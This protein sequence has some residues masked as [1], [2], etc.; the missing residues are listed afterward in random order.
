MSLF[1]DGPP[2]NIED[3]T[4]QDSGLLDVCRVQQI[5]ASVKL[6]LAHRELSAQ[7]ESL[8]EQ[9]RSVYSGTL[10]NSQL[11]LGN[12]AITPALR[13]WHT[14]QAL[15]LIYRDAY[16]NQLNDRFQAKWAEYRRLADNERNNL[17]DIGVGIVWDP[18]LQPNG[19]SLSPTPASEV[20][21]TFYFSIAVLNSAGEQSAPSPIES[22]NLSDGNAVEL[23]ILHHAANARGW[24]V[25]AGSQPGGMYLQNSAPI[26][27]D[28]SW[29]FFPSTALLSGAKPGTG[30]RPNTMRALPRLLGR[31]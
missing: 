12:V 15:S 7:I 24:N 25:Y 13:A 30:Q 17:R 21:G 14:W 1:A 28:A 20:G 22:I 3:L 10:T 18:L 29:S 26:P 31:G 4:D 23:Q 27:L 2:S 5:D 11:S 6:K 9:Q 8:F 16:F 19:P